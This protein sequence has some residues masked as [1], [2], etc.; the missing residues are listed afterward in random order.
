MK[1]IPNEFKTV[2]I[3]GEV[4][5]PGTYPLEPN[6][7]LSEL[8]NRAGGLKKDAFINGALFKRE[9]AKQEQQKRFMKANNQ[10]KKKI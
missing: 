2:K 3:E 6:D 1:Q 9:I 7:T 10:L 8:I 4:Y 5:F